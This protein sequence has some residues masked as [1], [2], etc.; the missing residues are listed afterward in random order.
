[1]K[2]FSNKSIDIGK[3]KIYFHNFVTRHLAFITSSEKFYFIPT[4][5][6]LAA[7]RINVVLI[8]VTNGKVRQSSV[9]ISSIMDIICHIVSDCK[10]I[11]PHSIIDL[12]LLRKQERMWNGPR[13]AWN[14]TNSCGTEQ[15]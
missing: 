9:Q 6:F 2:S 4:N 13:F 11:I 12:V 5:H 15:L 7:M 14:V 3:R 8:L 1:M 10:C